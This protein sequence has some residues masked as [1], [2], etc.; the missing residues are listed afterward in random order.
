M[1]CDAQS[2]S[3]SN[4]AGQGSSTTVAHWCN[5]CTQ[6]VGAPLPWSFHK[7]AGSSSRRHSPSSSGVRSTWSS[8]FWDPLA[9]CRYSRVS[10]AALARSKISH[11]PTR[12]HSKSELPPV[13]PRI[14]LTSS[15]LCS[16]RHPLT[17]SSAAL[18]RL[19]QS[20]PVLGRFSAS[21]CCLGC[22]A[23]AELFSCLR[24]LGGRE[25]ESQFPPPWLHDALCTPPL[26]GSSPHAG[27][28]LQDNS[29]ALRSSS[30]EHPP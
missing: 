9:P 17:A 1:S 2:Y 6:T 26:V 25:W 20:A 28:I 24:S 13:S 7:N 30:N 22:V 16:G 27:R 21:F 23:T 4:N 8:H 3:F 15:Y 10:P 19:P 29:V 5:S 11:G 18:G 14:H 12:L